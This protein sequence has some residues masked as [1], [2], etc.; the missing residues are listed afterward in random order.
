MHVR[1]SKLDFYHS[2]DLG[3]FYVWTFQNVCL[4]CK[5]IILDLFYNPVDVELIGNIL[6]KIKHDGFNSEIIRKYY[7]ARV[8]EGISKARIHK[9]LCT[10]GVLSEMLAKPFPDATKD[11][12]VRL[13]ADIEKKNLSDWAKR[14]YKV[15]L[16]HFYKW[17]RNWDDGL[18]P[19][20]RWIKKP[21]VRKTGIRY[22]QRIY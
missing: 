4:D 12:F 3:N 2:S 5:T 13:V 6:E 17:M 14:D 21:Q 18:P 11:D 22:S 8:A 16:K 7:D 1:F 19:E 9:C 15:I 10:L 20:V